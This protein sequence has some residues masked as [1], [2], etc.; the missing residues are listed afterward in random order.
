MWQRFKTCWNKFFDYKSYCKL[1][2][3]VSFAYFVF[4]V[5]YL[6]YSWFTFPEDYVVPVFPE[7]TADDPLYRFIAACLGVFLFSIMLLFTYLPI[8]VDFIFSVLGAVFK[9]KSAEESADK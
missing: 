2:L 3:Q 5:V 4:S 6:V 7:L 9:W 8:L 1:Q